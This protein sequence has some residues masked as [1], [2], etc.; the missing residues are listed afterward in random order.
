MKLFRGHIPPSWKFKSDV[1]V[2]RLLPGKG[3]LAV[4]LRD[5]ANKT[6][7][8]AGIEIG[9][10]KTLWK[11]LRFENGW[12]VT[13][14]TIYE[15][16]ILLQQFVRPD[17]PTA[18]KVFAVDLLSG[19][20][21]WQNDS[22]TYL[23]AAEGGVICAKRTLVSD[24]I[25]SL[26][27]RTGIEKSIS[28]PVDLSRS[29]LASGTQAEN[30]ILPELLEPDGKKSYPEISDALRNVLPPD[31]HAPSAIV[32]RSGKTIAGFHLRNGEDERGTA[33]YDSHL[34]IVDSN[35]KIMFRDVADTNVYMPITDFYF[36]AETHLI[37]VRNSNEIVAVKLG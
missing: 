17:M 32:Y 11:D 35:G 24:E 13:I 2:W 12:W 9:S 20:I 18:G 7:S 28:P 4:E 5:T 19:K 25:V 29:G 36:V 1:K 23:Y 6:A 14:N 33:L 34:Q 16:V 26:D 31:A 8:F 22:L 27:Y 3:V 30:F 37:Y 15:D 21:L 10:G